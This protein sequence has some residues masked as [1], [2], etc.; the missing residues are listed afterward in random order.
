MFKELAAHGRGDG[1]RRG[2]AIMFFFMRDILPNAGGE[3]MNR[4]LGF[5]GIAAFDGIYELSMKVRD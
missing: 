1:W 2:S 3:D 4:L 5:I